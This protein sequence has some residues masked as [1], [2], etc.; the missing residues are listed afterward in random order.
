MFLHQI[1]EDYA[2]LHDLRKEFQMK[3]VYASEIMLKEISKRFKI[4]NP[5]WYWPHE[6]SQLFKNVGKIDEMDMKLRRNALTIIAKDAPEFYYGREAIMVAEKEFGISSEEISSFSGIAASPG[7]ATG[8]AR[9]AHSYKEAEAK[10][11]KGDILVT[12]MTTPD[13]MP[14]MK[15]ISAIV[16]DEGGITSHAA[17]ISREM[18]IPCIVGTGIATKMLKDGMKIEV[19]A[20]QNVVKVLK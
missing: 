8:T 4:R 7:M 11:M 12:G 18:N 5:E 9:V 19:D 13:F 20:Y 17:V 14:S 15:K 3:S 6:I 1:F 10:I 16:T 2:S